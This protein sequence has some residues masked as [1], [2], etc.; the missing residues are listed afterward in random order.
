LRNN[1]AGLARAETERFLSA[2]LASLNQRQRRTP[3]IVH[4]SSIWLVLL[5]VVGIGIGL[6]LAS[7][8]LEALRRPPQSPKRLRWA[9]DIAIDYVTVDG[10]R[11]RYIRAGRGANLVLLHTLRTQLD[12]FEKVV[13]E[14]AREFTV[15]ALDFP[16]HGYSDIPTARYDADF[17]SLSVEHFLD[18][19]DLCAVTLCGVSIGGSVSLILAGRGNGRVDRVVA[20]NPYDYAEG[21]GLARSALLGWVVVAAARLPVV[22]ETFMRLRNF[23]IMKA[24][25]EGGV[26]SR[27]SIPPD[28]LKEMYEVGNRRGHYRAFLSLLRNAGSWQAA[29][30]TYR[31]IRVPAMLV[32]GDK[33]WARVGER[34]H[35]RD[36]IPHVEMMTQQ[37]AGHFLPLDRPSEL[38]ALIIRFAR[39]ERV[40][41]VP[42][43]P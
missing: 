33:D 20:V 6:W 8:V 27:V 42:R 28:L 43:R 25:L 31:T 41:A 1:V 5:V 18:A 39:A 24:V 22:G 34:E 3:V 37:G 4:Q 35:D 17:F 16:G 7:H 12:L 29:T 40:P 32:W 9:P 14:L 21:R 36:L 38:T 2:D 26:A 30:T 19:L 11:L 10:C 23:M 15:Y 13:P